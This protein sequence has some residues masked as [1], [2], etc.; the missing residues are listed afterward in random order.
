MLFMLLTLFI[1]I[2]AEDVIHVIDV[3]INHRSWRDII[4]GKGEIV[5][6]G[7]SL[8]ECHAGLCVVSKA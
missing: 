3:L 7:Q 8:I 1:F 5:A 4:A 2:I 6:S